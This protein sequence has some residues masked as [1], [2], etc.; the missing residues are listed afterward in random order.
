MRLEARCNVVLA[1]TARARVWPIQPGT[2]EERHWPIRP[3][4]GLAN[5]ARDPL[6]DGTGQ[7]GTGRGLANTA[8][9]PL[10]PEM[11]TRSAGRETQATRSTDVATRSAGRPEDEGSAGLRR[12]GR[13]PIR[14]GPGF[15]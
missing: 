4:R 13:W 2:T 6:K 12:G 3:G 14:R 5:T 7:Y 11:A 8:R 9:D 15:G 10:T 1:N